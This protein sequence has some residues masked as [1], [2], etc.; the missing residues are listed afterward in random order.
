MRAGKEP[1]VA[2][3]SPISAADVTEEILEAAEAIYDGWFA[4]EQRIDWENF[5][6]R[7]DGIPLDDGTVLDLGMDTMSPAIKAIKSHIRTYAK[8]E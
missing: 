2:Y 3:T 5:F 7:L 6:D 4:D 8:S 1:A